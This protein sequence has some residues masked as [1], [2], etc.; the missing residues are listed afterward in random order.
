M[1][2]P[3]HKLSFFHPR[4]SS[5]Q[6]LHVLFTQCKRSM[7]VKCT[8][9]FLDKIWK[10]IFRSGK[11]LNF[12]KNILG[13]GKGRKTCTSFYVYGP[14]LMYSQRPFSPQSVTGMMNL[15]PLCLAI[16]LKGRLKGSLHR[17]SL[18]M[19]FNSNILLFC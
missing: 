3:T 16:S 12:M 1:K 2:G 11:H 10:I 17:K 8:P 4:S 6:Q 13:L 7:R 19:T 18:H 14:I 15:L 5:V 9:F